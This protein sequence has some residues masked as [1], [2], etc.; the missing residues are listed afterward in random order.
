MSYIQNTLGTDEKIEVVAKM[1]W[2]AYLQLGIIGFFAFILLILGLIINMSLLIIGFILALV[3]AVLNQ[4]T[5]AAVGGII[6]LIMPVYTG[7]DSGY[8][9]MNAIILSVC[10]ALIVIIGMFYKNLKLK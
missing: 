9:E 4:K 10:A 2:V 3:M 5:V 6:A 1:H 8:F 7:I